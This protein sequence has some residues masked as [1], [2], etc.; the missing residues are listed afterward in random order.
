MYIEVCKIKKTNFKIRYMVPI[1]F[2][3]NHQKAK[4]K[5]YWIYAAALAI[6][7]ICM[8]VMLSFNIIHFITSL[9][10]G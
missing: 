5:S 2:K 7:I 6:L 10:K 8:V 9:V 1:I 4:Q 3:M